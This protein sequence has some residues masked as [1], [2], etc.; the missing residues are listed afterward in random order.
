MAAHIKLRMH[1]HMCYTLMVPPPNEK[2]KQFMNSYN[3][4]IIICDWACKNLGISA[5]N[6]ATCSENCTYLSHCLWYKRSVNFI[7]FIVDLSM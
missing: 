4:I 7:C 1:L 3:I 5:Q 6:I 2:V